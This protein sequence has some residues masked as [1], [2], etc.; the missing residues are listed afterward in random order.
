MNFEEGVQKLIDENEELFFISKFLKDHTESQ[1]YLVGGA[2][3]DILLKRTNKNID[4]DFVI[5]NINSEKIETW[6]SQIGTINLTGKNFGVLKFMPNK[7]DPKKMHFIDIAL[8]RTETSIVNSKGGY[9]DFK[10]HSDKNL[11]IETDLSRRDFTINAMAID[12]RTYELIDPFNGQNDLEQKTIRAVGEPKERFDEDMTRMMR[13]I[14]FSAELNF[15]INTQTLK[16]IRNKISHINNQQEENEQIQH[17]VPREVIGLEL[18]KSLHSNPSNTINLLIETEALKELFNE[19]YTLHAAKPNYLEPIQNLQHGENTLA[20]ILM[21]RKIDTNLIKNIFTQTGL[22][23]VSKTS[24]YKTDAQDVV[25]VVSKLEEKYTTKNI[26]DMRAYKFEKVFMNGRS[27]LLMDSLL[28]LKETDIL[29]TVKNRIKEICKKWNCKEDHKIPA[30]I[31]G[32]DVLSLDIKPG[33]KVRE[34][35]EKIRDLQLEGKIMTRDAALTWLKT[36]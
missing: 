23:S 3:R 24:P 33:P 9:K 20:L 5:Q 6:F 36:Q 8:P 26:Q 19:V 27:K 21:L 22:E 2:V 31:S 14:R 7:F 18:A 29:I 13:A 25:W 10:I 17:I 11:P 32:D 1:M 30:L 28:K 16:A 4:F 35:L 34:L 15:S 12:L